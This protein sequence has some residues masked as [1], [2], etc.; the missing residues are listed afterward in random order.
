MAHCNLSYWRAVRWIGTSLLS[1]SDVLWCTLAALNSAN[2]SGDAVSRAS[3]RLAE[4][5]AVQQGRIFVTD[6]NQYFIGRALAWSK[7]WKFWPDLS[8]RVMPSPL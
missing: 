7:V 1:Q 2:A 4:L 3:T 8:S 6:G 5:K